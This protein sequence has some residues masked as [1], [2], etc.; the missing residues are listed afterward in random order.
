MISSNAGSGGSGSGGG[1][2][3]GGVASLNR[4]KLYHSAMMTIITRLDAK[5]LEARKGQA[6]RDSGEY[7]LMLQEIAFKAH[8]KQMKDLNGEVLRSAITEQ[9]S[10]LWEDVRESVAR[11]QFA[12]LTFFV[13]NDETIYRFGHLTFQEYLCSMVINRMLA[14]EMERVKNIMAAGGVKK[15]LQ[16]SWWLTVTQFCLEGLMSEGE[17]GEEL[18]TRFAECMLEE[19]VHKEGVLK[20]TAKE[21]HSFDSM[22]A[23]ACLLRRCFKATALELGDG[24]TELN[25]EWLPQLARRY[26]PP[27]LRRLR[28]AG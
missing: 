15:M 11:G 21:L 16:G 10:A 4:W 1:A 13:E 20:L 23:F 14:T 7:M 2:G 25:A 26:R 5:T 19:V 8:C 18:A 12:V 28:C 6:G 9:T 24:K 17:R 3:A 22:A 27:T